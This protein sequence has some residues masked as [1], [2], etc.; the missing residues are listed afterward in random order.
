MRLPTRWVRPAEMAARLEKGDRRQGVFLYRPNCSACKACEPIRIDVD[1]F[2]PSRTHRRVF[3]QGE[4]VLETRMTRPKASPEKVELYNRHKIGRD[5]VTT[6]GLIDVEE[7]G[8][9]LV[10][11]CT[12]TIELSYYHKGTLVGVAV[13]DRATDAL[14]AV[15]CFYDPTYGALSIG[16]YSILKHIALCRDR[17]LRYLC[18]G[19]YISGCRAMEYKM[20][21]LPHERLIDGEWRGSN[22]STSSR[23]WELDAR[24]HKAAL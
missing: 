3:R 14:S 21:F 11:S 2:R 23:T 10:E 8:Q 12:D 20:R 7:Y 9:F 17:G 24:N 5:L 6:D 4:A 1:A 15:Y 22:P 19:L 18:L 16:T 13:T